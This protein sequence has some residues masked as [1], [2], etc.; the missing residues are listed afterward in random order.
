[1]AENQNQ[2]N[3]NAQQGIEI[4]P[5][6]EQKKIHGEFFVTVAVILVLFEAYL[7]IFLTI[8]PTSFNNIIIDFFYV[9]IFLMVFWSYVIVIKTPAGSIPLYWGFYIGDDD[10][11]RKRYCLICN[12]F[13][14]ERSKHCSICNTCV[15]NMDHHCPWVNNCIGFFNRKYFMQFIF[16]L[17]ILFIYHFIFS[18]FYL[19]NEFQIVINTKKT[20]YLGFVIIIINYIPT[21]VITFLFGKFV[22]YHIKLVLTNSS[23][24]ESLD[25]ENK[26]KYKKFCL[27]PKENFEQV[28]GK[29]KFYWFLPVNIEQAKPVGDGLLWKVSEHQ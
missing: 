16:Y 20:N 21:V 4:K 28:F 26:D 22:A 23:T 25:T 5:I 15:L 3:Q 7:F 8:P 14:P 17:E 9:L 10:E 11:K 24:I 29:N 13:K 19:Y 1:M 2:N 6:K 12:A 27:S 18:S